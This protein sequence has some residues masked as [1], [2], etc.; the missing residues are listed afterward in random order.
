MFRDT[1]HQLYDCK[2][3]SKDC[4]KNSEVSLFLGCLGNMRSQFQDYVVGNRM[5][6]DKRKIESEVQ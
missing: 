2:D 3:V 5:I 6:R 4:D 1:C